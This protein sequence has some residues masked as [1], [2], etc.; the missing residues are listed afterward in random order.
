MITALRKDLRAP[1]LVALLGVNTRFGN[2]KNP[3][4]PKVIEA[5]QALAAKDKRCAYVDT[6]GAETLLPSRT[7][8]TAAGTLEVGRRFA[9][10][11]LAVEKK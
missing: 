1:R 8:F 6:A 10:A 9:A 4:V 3:F 2:D 5:Q 11:L 7:H